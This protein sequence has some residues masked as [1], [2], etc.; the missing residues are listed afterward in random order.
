MVELYAA[1]DAATPARAPKPICHAGTS[2]FWKTS[3]QTFG[4]RPAH[5]SRLRN[6][7]A[8]PRSVQSA[9]L[10]APMPICAA[11]DVTLQCG[12]TLTSDLPVSVLL[13]AFMRPS[14]DKRFASVVEGIVLLKRKETW[15]LEL[16]ELQAA[17]PK[18]R[19]SPLPASAAV[20][21]PPKTTPAA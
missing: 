10:R 12:C 8:P 16:E 15:E 9:M 4:L 18:P 21:A 6:A 14:S 7:K 17:G 5:E 20:P 19:A 2:T 11:H 13:P 3:T 1:M